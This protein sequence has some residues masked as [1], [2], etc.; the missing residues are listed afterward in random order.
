MMEHSDEYMT[1]RQI[2]QMFDVVYQTARTDL[3]RLVE[4][5]H[6]IMEQRGREF[7]FI[8]NEHSE[9]WEKRPKKSIR[10]E[11]QKELGDFHKKG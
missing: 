10:D 11:Q 1:I 2:S 3:L 7:F 4:L 6:V 5:G 8:F 9:L